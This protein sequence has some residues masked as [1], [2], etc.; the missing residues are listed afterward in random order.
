MEN[1]YN[2]IFNQ[3]IGIRHN[4]VKEREFSAHDAPK[5]KW[6]LPQEADRRHRDTFEIEVYARWSFHTRRD[7]KKKLRQH[8]ATGRHSR[9]QL[10]SRQ[11]AKRYAN[12]IN[13][14]HVA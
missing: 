11:L 9:Q 4:W 7:S 13:L 6:P 8:L 1:L 3:S 14:T 10:G 2:F 12:V 5:C